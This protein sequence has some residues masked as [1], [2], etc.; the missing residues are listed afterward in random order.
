MNPDKA[1]E[2]LI[3]A[4]KRILEGKTGYSSFEPELSSEAINVQVNLVYK[5][6]HCS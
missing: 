5:L 1:P 3:R 2:I 4:A 6:P